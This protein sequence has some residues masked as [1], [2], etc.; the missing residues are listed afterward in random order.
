M[1]ADPRVDGGTCPLLFEAE[2]T[3]MFC[4]PYF[5]GVDILCTNAHGIHWTI[6]AIFVKFSQLILVKNYFNCCHQMSH[7][8]ANFGWGSAPDPAKGAYS[9]PRIPQLHLRGLLLRGG[10]RREW[11]E[12]KGPSTFFYG[13]TPIPSPKTPPCFS[14]LWVSLT[15]RPFWPC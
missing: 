15:A 3:L 7:L 5:F 14:A 6:G 10:K 8:K 9:A 2:G 1:G 4:L 13:S 12:G 11:M